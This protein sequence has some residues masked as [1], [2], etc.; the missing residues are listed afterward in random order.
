[1]PKRVKQSK[2][3]SR[4]IRGKY[5]GVTTI[6]ME[7]QEGTVIVLQGYAIHEYK[8][9]K[10]IE[11]GRDILEFQYHEMGK[12]QRRH[13]NERKHV[14]EKNAQGVLDLRKVNSKEGEEVQ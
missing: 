13:E 1:M 7:V 3:N 8:F 5:K 10:D 14:V 12:G 6:R 11:T 9:R 2:L 4:K